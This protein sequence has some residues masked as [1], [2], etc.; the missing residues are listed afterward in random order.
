[1][2]C[3]VAKGGNN[4]LIIH[5]KIFEIAI[6]NYFILR[7][8]TSL[9]YIKVNNDLTS[10]IIK[11]DVFSME[12]C[13]TKFKQHYANIYTEKDIN[14]L[15]R[16]GKL[17]FLTYLMPLINGKGFYHFE[18]ETA[19]FGKMDLVIDYLTQQF[20]LEIKLWH[21][22]NRHEDAYEQ[23]AACLKS[24]NHSCGYLLTF[25]FRQDV[26]DNLYES[27]WIECEGKKIFDIMLRVGNGK[28]SRRA[29]NR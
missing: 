8:K 29:K 20:I 9:N 3:F 5:N 14:F 19:N 4:K 6:S 22:N 1:M 21:G 17:I 26:G 2:F 23:L 16:D 10:D 27:K 28:K 25:D 15:E 24:K 18:S 7:T 11:D 13:L 12:L